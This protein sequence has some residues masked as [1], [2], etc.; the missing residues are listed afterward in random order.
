MITFTRVMKPKTVANQDLIFQCSKCK[1]LLAD[2][3]TFEHKMD[4]QRRE[5]KKELRRHV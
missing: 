1:A 4:H 5:L 2:R 3:Y